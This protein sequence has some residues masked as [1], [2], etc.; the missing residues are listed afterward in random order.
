MQLLS[1]Y[2]IIFFKLYTNIELSFLVFLHNP[3]EGL[4]G[5]TAQVNLL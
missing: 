5:K 4:G 1:L 2:Y 3:H